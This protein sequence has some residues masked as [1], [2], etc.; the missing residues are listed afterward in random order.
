MQ[1]T[2]RTYWTRGAVALLLLALLLL[3]GRALAQNTEAPL[4]VEP[5]QQQRGDVVTLQRDIVIDGNVEGDVT[6]WLGDITVQGHVTGDVVS[7]SGNIVLGAGA[8]VEGSVLRLAGAIE[9]HSSA[10]VAGQVIGEVPVGGMAASLLGASGR[11][12]AT[13]AGWLSYSLLSA[14]LALLTLAIALAA[15]LVWPRRT[16]NISDVL[17][18]APWR[19]LALGALTLLLLAQALVLLAGLLALSL[20]GLLLL[21]PLL[22]LLH[23]PASYG[24]AVLAHVLVRRPGRRPERAVTPALLTL[25]VGVMLLPV[26]LLGILSPAGGLLLFYL[27]ASAGLGAALLSRG[28][29]LAP[30]RPPAQ[31]GHELTT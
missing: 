20:V 25:T 10:Q 26:V 16:A 6:S 3:P 30:P 14:V 28:G 7:Y 8:R 21:P 27:L 24:L 19:S 5:G 17:L 13:S 31:S 15:T 1:N 22:L 18:S 2:R 4:H 9:Q 11:P 29:V 12:L 23:L